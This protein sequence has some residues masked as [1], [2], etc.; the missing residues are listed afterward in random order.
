MNKYKKIAVIS[1]IICMAF[2]SIAWG[3]TGNI[4][5]LSH[6]S[7]LTGH[8]L[9]LNNMEFNSTGN[10]LLSSG[11]KGEVFLWNI[12]TGIGKKIIEYNGINRSAI[13][14]KDDKYIITSGDYG[15]VDGWMINIQDTNTGE[16][17]D[18]IRLY[19]DEGSHSQYIDKIDLSATA[20]EI[21]LDSK[22]LIIGCNEQGFNSF[23]SIRYYDIENKREISKFNVD[24]VIELME[25]H[26]S[27]EIFAYISSYISSGEYAALTVRDKN[28]NKILMSTQD[29]LNLSSNNRYDLKFSPD[30]KYMAVVSY[31]RDEAQLLIFDTENNYQQIFSD[32]IYGQVYPMSGKISF[33]DKDK[34]LIV[35]DKLYFYEKG[36]VKLDEEISTSIHGQNDIGILSPTTEYM[37]ITN[38]SQINIYRS[39]IANL[40]DKPKNLIAKP[41]DQQVQLT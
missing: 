1:I 11:K 6:L 27:K 21:S 25:Y 26:P 39:E 36:F 17:V 28:T 14:S 33:S 37:A 20:L 18:S 31:Q 34:L 23:S 8:T 40:I 19:A 3:D 15:Y 9:G 32:T 16:I 5:K 29:R 4:L 12:E 13:F 22:T 41:S 35:G 7:S 30:G 2:S 10:L 24:G 38:G